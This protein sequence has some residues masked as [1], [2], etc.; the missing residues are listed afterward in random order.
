[1]RVLITG[2]AGFLGQLLAR[3][4]LAAGTLVVAG[5]DPAPVDELV[6]LDLVEPPGDLAADPRVRVRVG[7]LV[8]LM[9]AEA[10]VDVVFHL[11]GVV[12]GAAEADF[13]AGMA[14]NVDGTRAVLQRCR[15]QA[16]PPVLVFSSSVAVFGQDPALPQ[17]DEV[18]DETFPR[19][20]TSYGTQ[21]LIGE[22]LVADC[23]RKGFVRGRS[24]R[25]M[26]VSVRPGRPNAAASG[27]LSGIVRE[28]LAGVRAVCPVPPDTPV[29]LSSP[30]RTI[31]GILTAAATDEAT[32]GSRA[33]V[34]LPG[35]T[36]TPR[37]MAEAL[38][39]VAGPG[40]SDLIDWRVDPAVAAMVASWPARVRT[41]RAAALGLEPERSFD[42]IIRAYLED[43]G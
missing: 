18:G 13:D 28:P 27:F 16:V 19:P 36:T 34:T 40:T 30:R 10:D 5:A 12:S 3:R 9:P 22:L 7:G 24:V 2:G 29:A 38:D 4:I 41:D 42:D 17:V 1:M 26:T 25:L 35:L 32:W 31:E 14:G 11:A 21:K 23:T 20:Q 43:L 37:R 6:L 33:A 39:R 15:A 8:D